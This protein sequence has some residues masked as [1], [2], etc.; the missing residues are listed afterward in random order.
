MKKEPH[1]LKTD[2]WSL[3]IC[4]Y[5]IITGRLPFVQRSPEATKMNIIGKPIR[6]SNGFWETKSFNVKDLIYKMLTKNSEERLS[7]NEVLKHPWFTLE[8]YF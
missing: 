6:F 4:L 3:G 1:C 8:S 2:V 5:I 7:I